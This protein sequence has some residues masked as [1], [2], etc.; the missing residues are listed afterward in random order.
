MSE[1][2][3]PI[4]ET[5]RKIFKKLSIVEKATVF[6]LTLLVI[7]ISSNVFLRYVMDTGIVWA[8]EVSRLIFIWVVFLGAYL[9]FKRNSH[10]V[11]NV[12][13]NKLPVHIRRYYHLLVGLIE[14][15]FMLFL[16]FYGIGQV[17]DTAKFGQITPG[18]GVPMSW[19][20]VVIPV[21]AL[22]M[23]MAIIA[24]ALKNFK[25]KRGEE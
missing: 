18:L 24:I 21:T 13:A 17:M 3:P 25:N 20:Y 10:A 5:N 6:L 9:A 1:N 8:E 12:L 7:V 22:I 4:G 19:Y 11:V 23:A 15:G 16:L 2:K 14:A